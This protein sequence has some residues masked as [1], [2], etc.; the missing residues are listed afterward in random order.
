MAHLDRK[1]INIDVIL[2]MGQPILVKILMA[3]IATICAH[4]EHVSGLIGLDGT[5]WDSKGSLSH[6]I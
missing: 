3:I 6:V 5:P 1:P 2:L 4:A